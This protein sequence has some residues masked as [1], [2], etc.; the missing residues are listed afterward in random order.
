M[1]AH[2]CGMIGAG[3]KPQRTSVSAKRADA[4]AIATSQ[5]ATKPTPP[6]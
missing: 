5:Q 2:S 6:P 4:L 1:A 3:V